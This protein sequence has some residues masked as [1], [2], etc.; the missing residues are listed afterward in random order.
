MSM[1]AETVEKFDPN[2]WGDRVSALGKEA[3]NGTG[4]VY[5]LYQRKF[6]ALVSAAIA[7]LPIEHQQQAKAIAD[8]HGYSE[9]DEELGEDDCGHGLDPDCCPLGC[10][11]IDDGWPI[12]DHELP[13]DAE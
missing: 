2:A 7:A 13:D 8:A 1:H 9:A 12:E 6:K 11:D 5:L 3:C 10:G 4:S